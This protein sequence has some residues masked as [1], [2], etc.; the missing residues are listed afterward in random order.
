MHET[1]D[2]LAKPNE[3]FVGGRF[4]DMGTHFATGVMYGAEIVVS[5]QFK[6]SSESSK[7]V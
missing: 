2:E 3:D 1:T 7:Y 4:G 6:P 5:F